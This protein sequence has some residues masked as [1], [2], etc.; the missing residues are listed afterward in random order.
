MVK[1]A[2]K[3]NEVDDTGMSLVEDA[4]WVENKR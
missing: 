2:N 1:T 4:L 3:H